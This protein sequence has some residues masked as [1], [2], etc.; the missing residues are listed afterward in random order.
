MVSNVFSTLPD[1]W[2]TFQVNTQRICS[3]ELPTRVAV[4]ASVCVYLSMCASVLMPSVY[5][6]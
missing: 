1:N 4:C 2:L 3:F 6:N 5:F